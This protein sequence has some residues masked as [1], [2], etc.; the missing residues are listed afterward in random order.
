MTL[1]FPAT[2]TY[3]NSN[4]PLMF[5]KLNSG[6]TSVDFVRLLSGMMCIKLT[7]LKTEY[8]AHWCWLPQASPAR[9]N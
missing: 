3:P 8:P 6:K 5:G 2:Y 9:L 7:G 1:T 4:A